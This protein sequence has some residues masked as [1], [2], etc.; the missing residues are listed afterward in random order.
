[1]LQDFF[2]SFFIIFITELEYFHILINTLP[3]VLDQSISDTF[4][5]RF[6]KFVK[7]R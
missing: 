4:P 5:I 1:M 6:H 3:P 7:F 2:I